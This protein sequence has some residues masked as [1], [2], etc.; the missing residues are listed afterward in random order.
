MVT[1][2]VGLEFWFLNGVSYSYTWFTGLGRHLLVDHLSSQG[3]TAGICETKMI[4]GGCF[5]LIRVLL[6][7]DLVAGE[8]NAVIIPTSC[9]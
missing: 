3:R 5:C 8:K 6:T 1:G 9:L 2:G 4:V 7:G